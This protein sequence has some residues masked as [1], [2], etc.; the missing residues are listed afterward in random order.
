MPVLLY[1][2]WVGLANEEV[3]GGTAG[4]AGCQ[5]KKPVDA[6]NHRYAQDLLTIWTIGF[7][8]KGKSSAEKLDRTLGRGGGSL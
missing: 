3:V 4:G 2:L 5:R 1:G 6:E 8:R 7:Y